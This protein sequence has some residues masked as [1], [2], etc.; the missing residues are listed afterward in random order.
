MCTVQF[1]VQYLTQGYYEIQMG[2]VGIGP[3][4]LLSTGRPTLRPE[5]EL[6]IK[7]LF[8]KVTPNLWVEKKNPAQAITYSVETVQCSRSRKIYTESLTPL[9]PSPVGSVSPDERC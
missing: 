4:N 8:K 3:S 2:E 7:L 9:S 1:G 6:P 5:L